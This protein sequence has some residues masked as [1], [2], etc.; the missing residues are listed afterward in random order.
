MLNRIVSGLKT[1]HS[2]HQVVRS[3]VNCFASSSAAKETVLPNGLR[4]VTEETYHPTSTVALFINAGSSFET[5]ANNGTAH[6]LEHLA[7]KGTGRRT[8]E[9]LGLEVENIGASLNAYTSREHTVFL[10]KSLKQDVPKTVDIIADIVQNSVFSEEA[11]EAERSTILREM[12]EVESNDGEV[13]FDHLHSIAF[14]ESS[15]GYTILGPAENIRSI[16]RSDILE[17][18]K[19]YYTAD[20]MILV[21]AG[22]V[23]H[24][25]L[26]N[27][28][29][30]AFTSLPKSGNVPQLT[31]PAFIGS[32]VIHF[33]S[34]KRD[35]HLALGFEGVSFSDPD[36]FTLMVLQA[37]IG[38]WDVNSGAGKNVGSSLNE[39]VAK[40]GLA[41]KV[42]PFSSYYNKTGIFGL[43]AI[44]QDE[45]VEDLLEAI[46]REW[47]R[48]GH[49]V[50]GYEVE[51]AKNKL[52]SALLLNL[53][54]TTPLAED[55]GRQY[56]SSGRHLSPEELF[57]RLDLVTD[58]HVKEF[59]D[60][61]IRDNCFSLAAI[62][63]V[64][65]IPDYN[66]MRSWTSS[67][68]L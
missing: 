1:T 16:K 7:F 17:Y 19:N 24:E 38:S 22:G 68:L 48:L 40:Y 46:F 47:R 59:I 58:K 6:F 28:A 62:G 43:H 20:R 12:E 25:E 18:V 2:A 15:L 34:D 26:V 30:K 42:H 53:D 54:G 49:S 37:I 66:T 63:N 51:R 4:V 13:I 67:K 61:K 3:S 9:G 14:Q 50:S 23:K 5:K 27:I 41:Q 57:A 65:H 60:R 56:L 31:K 44:T 29:S 32:Q 21:G 33:D 52:K 64:Q 45:H 10:A 36:Y 39:Y 35:I 11:I 8:K 55:I